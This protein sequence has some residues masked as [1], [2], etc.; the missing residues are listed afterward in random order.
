MIIGSNLPM[1]P[2]Q[3]RLHGPP[4]LDHVGFSCGDHSELERLEARLQELGIQG[5]GIVE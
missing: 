2:C 4:G 3:T 1:M 5:G